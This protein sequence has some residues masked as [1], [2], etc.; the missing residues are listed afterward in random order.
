MSFSILDV[1][2]LFLYLNIVG[3]KKYIYTYIYIYIYYIL[4]TVHVK[5]LLIDENVNITMC[6]NSSCTELPVCGQGWPAGC[7]RRRITP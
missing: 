5:V 7:H 6:L 3:F 1:S 2:F 4:K